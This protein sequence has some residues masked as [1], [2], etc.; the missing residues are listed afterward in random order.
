MIAEVF[1]ETVKILSMVFVLMTLVEYLV[2][3]FEEEIKRK[4]TGRPWTQYVAASALGA[5]P[6]CMDAF[7]V[8]SLY[9]SGV[10]GFGAL[11][12]VMLST[13]G[14]EAFV[15]LAMIP[16]AAI[17]VFAACFALGVVGGYLGDLFAEKLDLKLCKSCEVPIHKVEKRVDLRHFLKEHVW[18]HIIKQHIPQLFAWL[19]FTLIAV[20]WLISNFDLEALLPESRLWLII[21]A[22]LLGAIPESGPHLMLV[23]LFSKGLIPFSVLLV[24]TLSQDGHGL[25]P[26]LSHSLEDTLYVQVFTTLFALGV[27]LLLFLLG[28]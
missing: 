18:E 9:I 10:V 20:E 27:G 8:V 4:V 12:S 26:L 28:F 13:A 1:L 3:R 16:D 6:G 15:M 11:S 25:L 7:F 24:N 2:L 22:A 5:I 23:V 19:F 21:F 17:Q 14:D